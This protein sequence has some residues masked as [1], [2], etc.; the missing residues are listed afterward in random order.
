MATLPRI[1][2]RLRP[3]VVPLVRIQGPLATGLRPLGGVTLRQLERPLEAAFTL[4]RAVAVAL[5]IDSP[6]GSPAQAEL[7]AGR[8]CTLARRHRRPTLAFVEGLAA[9]GGYW[10]ACAADEIFALPTSLVGSIGVITSGFGLHELL[11]RHGIE[12]R[13][14]ARGPLKA[15]LDPF[16][17][18]DPAQ[19]AVL[20]ELHADLYASF[21]D[22][23]RQRR[24]PRLQLDEATLGS[25]RLW[26]GRQARELGLVDGLGE[27]EDVVRARF[28]PAVRLRPLGPARRRWPWGLVERAATC[29]AEALLDGLEARLTT[30]P[31]GFGT[32]RPFPTEGDR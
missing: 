19:L 18:E 16:R 4:K 28:G 23:V 26:T 9:S 31:P 2:T 20:E 30:T 25:G 32:A 6:G 17:P 1:L 8:I 14:H 15:F 12:R 24:G 22:W 11:R 10:I 5:V 21:L 29:F 27:V 3:P 7:I 13:I